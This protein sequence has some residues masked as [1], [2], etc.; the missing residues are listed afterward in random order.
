MFIHVYYNNFIKI[1]INSDDDL[2][3]EKALNIQN[4]IAFFRP[5]FN[6][7]YKQY[8]HDMCLTRCYAN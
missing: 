6:N 8:R 7:T 4:A 2:P 5:I 1:G 3:L